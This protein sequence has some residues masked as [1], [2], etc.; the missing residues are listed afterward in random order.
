MSNTSELLI[1]FIQFKLIICANKQIKVLPGE[2]TLII[3]SAPQRYIYAGLKHMHI[4][5]TI[6][7][8][9]TVTVF[10]KRNIHIK[11][12]VA[13]LDYDVYK[14]IIYA[15]QRKRKAKSTHSQVGMQQ[16]TQNTTS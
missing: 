14:S 15:L 13:S 5:K 2:K 1:N 9:K 16:R 10:P 6:K 3:T 11:I 7:N 4:N 8:P 12:S